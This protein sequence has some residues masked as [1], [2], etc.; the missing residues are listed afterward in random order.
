MAKSFRGKVVI[1]VCFLA[2][3][4]AARFLVQADYIVFDL[5]PCK[6]SG[7]FVVSGVNI[8]AVVCYFAAG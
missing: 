1:V 3:V 8:V 5:E 4:L 6:Y 7:F 2:E